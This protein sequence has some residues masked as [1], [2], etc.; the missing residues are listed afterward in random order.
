MDAPTPQS[1]VIQGSNFS[2]LKLKEQTSNTLN[3][4]YYTTYSIYWKSPESIQMSTNNSKGLNIKRFYQKG[5]LITINYATEKITSIPYSSNINWIKIISTRKRLKQLYRD[6]KLTPIGNIKK[7]NREYQVFNV[8]FN[9]QFNNDNLNLIQI[10]KGSVHE[11]KGNYQEHHHLIFDLQTKYLSEVNWGSNYSK[12]IAKGNMIMDWNAEVN[13]DIFKPEYQNH[14]EQYTWTNDSINQNLEIN[15]NGGIGSLNYGDHYDKIFSLFGKPDE[16]IISENTSTK[17]AKRI[18]I[19]NVSKTINLNVHSLRYYDLGLYF[20]IEES[21]ITLIQFSSKYDFSGIYH[22]LPYLHFPGNIEGVITFNSTFE[23]AKEYFG[24]RLVFDKETT[25]EGYTSYFY[26]LDKKFGV[27]FGEEGR[28]LDM[29]FQKV[30]TFRS[31][32]PR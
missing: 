32:P 22:G 21:L 4:D 25:I 28:M 20:L 11:D 30:R 16:M 15:L 18:K 1:V 8:K 31:R 9:Y 5:N 27:S 12:R 3:R 14:F 17:K 26:I 19:Y 6:S 13:S 2:G 24:D 7:N 29:A 10:L 23:E